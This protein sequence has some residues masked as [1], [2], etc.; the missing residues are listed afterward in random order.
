MTQK[1][2][3]ASNL[4]SW[5]RLTPTWKK[6]KWP[7]SISCGP[8]TQPS[9][10]KKKHDLWPSHLTQS[11]KPNFFPGHHNASQA[12]GIAHPGPRLDSHRTTQ[13]MIGS[14]SVFKYIKWIQFKE[15]KAELESL[16]AED[17]LHWSL[18]KGTYSLK[19]VEPVASSGRTCHQGVDC[20]IRTS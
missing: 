20:A 17:L 14:S 4:L 19:Q 1:E 16:P 7:T 6:C 5:L 11:Q 2:R 8:Q 10:G 3:R 13:Q 15:Q 9:V 12:K 18:V